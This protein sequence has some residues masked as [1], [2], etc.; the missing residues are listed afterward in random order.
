MNLF[1]TIRSPYLKGYILNKG[2]LRM[3]INDFINE[4]YNYI[5]AI[6]INEY[7]KGKNKMLYRQYDKDDFVNEVMLFFIKKYNSY[8]K[9]LCK[10]STFIIKNCIYC[11]GELRERLTKSNRCIDFI[12]YNETDL[13]VVEYNN[14]NNE[15]LNVY[16]NIGKDDY[17]K[18]LS[19]FSEL[20][21]EEKKLCYYKLHGLSMN[22]MEKITKVSRQTLW[23]KFNIIKEKLM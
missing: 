6:A 7:N 16:E 1:M 3:N 4:N 17:Y 12:T 23:R 18:E 22:E 5:K 20:T 14:N 15:D 21:K 19:V 10:P 2:E 8:D 11:A 13:M 9:T